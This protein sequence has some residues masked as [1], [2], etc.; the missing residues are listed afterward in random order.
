MCDA[1][2]SAQLILR[3]CSHQTP[4]VAHH[5][6]KGGNATFTLGRGTRKSDQ[7]IGSNLPELVH[8]THATRTT[9]H[10]TMAHARKRNIDRHAHTR[11]KSYGKEEII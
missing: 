4:V 7:R 2:L 9:R 5:P 10:D 8:A 11:N 1:Y 3:L 6:A